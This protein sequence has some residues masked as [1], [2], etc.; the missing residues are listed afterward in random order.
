MAHILVGSLWQ[1]LILYALTDACVGGLLPSLS[2][3]L[4]ENSQRGDEGGVYGIDNSVTSAGRT[5]GPLLGAA[6]ALW[7][8]PR[9]IFVL[10]GLISGAAPPPQRI[11]HL[12]KCPGVVARQPTRRHRPSGSQ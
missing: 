6:C 7:F 3:M 2:A 12:P 5:V 8:S 10:T 1:L 11:H 4:A 9:A